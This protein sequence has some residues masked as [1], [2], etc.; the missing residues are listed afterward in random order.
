MDKIRENIY[1]MLRYR[2][3]N[4]LTDSR[5]DEFKLSKNEQIL[6]NEDIMVCFVDTLNKK[7]ALKV[8][9]DMEEYNVKNYI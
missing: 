5:L 9:K 4:G 2:N 7:V 3:I 8:E 1:D 6:I